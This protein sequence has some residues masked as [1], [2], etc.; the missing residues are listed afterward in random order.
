MLARSASRARRFACVLLE[1]MAIELDA[2]RVFGLE[3]GPKPAVLHQLLER[4]ASEQVI[5]STT[6][7]GV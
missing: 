6:G 7:M 1:H 4:H 2:S 5:V 3:D